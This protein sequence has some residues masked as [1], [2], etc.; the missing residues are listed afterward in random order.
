MSD[1]PISALASLSTG[2]LVVADRSGRV[3]VMA[4]SPDTPATTSRA[5]RDAAR[6][7]VEA[8]LASTTE[9]PDDAK[10]DTDLVRADGVRTWNPGDLDEVTTADDTDPTWLRRRAAMNSLFGERS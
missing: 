6:A 10:L 5:E 1:A 3:T 4:A 7:R 8:F 2:Q 9:L